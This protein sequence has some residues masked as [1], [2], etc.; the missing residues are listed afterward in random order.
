MWG[1]I[2]AVNSFVVW[3]IAVIFLVYSIGRMV[4][5][6]E[7]KLFVI[8][9]IIFAVSTIAQMVIGVLAD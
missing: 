8:A 7:W 4:I 2:M 3:P 5:F 1:T 6:F 9:V